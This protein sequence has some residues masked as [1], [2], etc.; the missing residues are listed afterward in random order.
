MSTL[1]LVRSLGKQALPEYTTGEVQH[2]VRLARITG[3]GKYPHGWTSDFE[4]AARGFAWVVG[5]DFIKK[6]KY[7]ASVNE[8]FGVGSGHRCAVYSGGEYNYRFYQGDIPDAALGRIGEAQKCDMHWFTI[9]SNEE[10]PIKK[11]DMS[12]RDPVIIGWRF[13]PHLE[14]SG[15]K[16]EMGDGGEYLPSDWNKG[17]VIAIWDN[18]K[19]LEI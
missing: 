16:V 7:H 13:N 5:I 14:V 19:E 9:H 1:G 17:F 6:F 15:E 11:M 18:D 3:V 10:L 4:V 12:K 2:Q 8:Y